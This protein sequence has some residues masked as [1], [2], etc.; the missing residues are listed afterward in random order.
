MKNSLKHRARLALGRVFALA[1]RIHSRPYKPEGPVVVIAPHPDDETLG[2]GG[3]VAYLARS[4]AHVHTIFL[5]DGEASHPAHPLLL[6]PE[7][8]RRRKDEALAALAALGIKEPQNSAVFL[9]APDGQLDR[10]S[11]AERRRVVDAMTSQIQT[12][13]PT[14][15]LAPY[16]FGG[17]TEHTAANSLVRAALATAGGGHL[18]EYPVWAWWNPLRLRAQLR[19]S[20]DNLRLPLDLTLWAAKRRALA[21]HRTQ[22]LATPPWP[23]PVL[24]AAITSACMSRQ[25]FYFHHHVPAGVTIPRPAP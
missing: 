17:S 18:L 4:G 5:S 6:P 15:V 7:L 20:A 25:E 16:R 3:L 11:T 2:C 1:L 8:A 22:I 24:P 21:C 10:L 13:K 23:E 19:L 9:G 12:L 14:V